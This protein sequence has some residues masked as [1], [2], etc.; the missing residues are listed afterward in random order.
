MM[1]GAH[2]RTVVAG[3]VLVLCALPASAE[4]AE[5]AGAFGFEFGQA[6]E[7]AELKP[8]GIEAKGGVRYGFIPA[9]P[10]APLT[11]YELV[12]TPRSLRVFRITARGTFSSMQRCREELVRLE[13]AL[14]RKYV[15]TSGKIAMAFGEQPEIAFGRSARKI[16]GVCTGAILKKTLTLTYTDEDLVQAARDEGGPAGGDARQ[17]MEAGGAGRDESGL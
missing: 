4:Q 12:L 3:V 14:E 17:A 16:Y 2:M 15:K 1:T 11:E 9:N 7:T 5:V 8:L 13:Q 10:Y 6:V